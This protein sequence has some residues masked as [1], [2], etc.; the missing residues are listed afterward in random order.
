MVRFSKCCNP[1]P[2]DE[3]I[4]YI[5]RGRGVSIHRKDCPNIADLSIQDR[6]IEVE[7]DNAKKV[8]YLA[9]IQIKATDRSGLLSEITQLLTEKNLAVTSLNARTN[10][11]KIALIN[12]VLEIKSVEQL[13]ELMRKIRS[14]NG[15]I[16]VYR[17]IT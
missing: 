15:V 5:T 16:D 11:E 7:W 2:G 1:V 3:I 13:N 10:R 8:S 17:V 4:G 9:E 12:L 14:I 6:F